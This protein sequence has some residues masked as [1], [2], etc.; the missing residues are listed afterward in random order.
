[1]DPSVSVT[2]LSL[3]L[4]VVI[5]NVVRYV[6]LPISPLVPQAS[7]GCARISIFAVC[8]HSNVSF[9]QGRLESIRIY[10]I[11][12]Y[13]LVQIVDKLVPVVPSDL[14]KS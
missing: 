2:F 9:N 5:G 3:V 1:M 11:H 13:S 7:S 8:P 10:I 12:K 4:T 6:D 14:K